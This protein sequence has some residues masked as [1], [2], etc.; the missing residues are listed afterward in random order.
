L[1]THAISNKNSLY[2]AALDFKDAFGSVNHQLLN[3]NLKNLG[4]PTRLRN[5]IMDS[6]KGS[7]VRIWNAGKASRS[8]D[9]KK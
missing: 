2:V 6:Y 3:I 5:L 8:I 9:I 1:I 4:V 7:Q